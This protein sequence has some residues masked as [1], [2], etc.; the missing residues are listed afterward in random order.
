LHI[1]I[2]K[3]YICATL[4]GLAHLARALAWQARGGRFESDILHKNPNL[5][6]VFFIFS[7]M[8]YTYIIYST[9]LNKYYVGS[10]Q[11]VEERLLD[12]LNSRSKYTKVAKD[13][14][15]KHFETFLSRSEACKRELQIKKMKSRK[16]IENLIESKK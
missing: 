3:C 11:N 5:V 8:Y 10:C 13:W 2:I 9:T 4:G 12:H 7:A 1:P 15:L 6:W 16:Y 14:E